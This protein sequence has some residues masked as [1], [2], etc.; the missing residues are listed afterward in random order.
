MMGG[1]GGEKENQTYYFREKGKRNLELGVVN[2][3]FLIG[4]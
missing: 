2:G 4:P 1:V 3:G